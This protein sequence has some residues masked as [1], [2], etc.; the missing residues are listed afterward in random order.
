VS[1]CGMQMINLKLQ[2]MMGLL[3]FHQKLSQK[4]A[5]FENNIVRFYY[6]KR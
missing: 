4:K 5:L 6:G 3:S 1:A 2:E